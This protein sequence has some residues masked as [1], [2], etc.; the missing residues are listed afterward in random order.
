MMIPA[1][2]QDINEE[3]YENGD[4]IDVKDL[5]G[6]WVAPGT[7]YSKIEIRYDGKELKLIVGKLYTYYFTQL[8]PVFVN[9]IKGVLI[10]WPPDDCEIRLINPY[11]LEVTYTNFQA[12]SS[13]SRYRRYST[14]TTPSAAKGLPKAQRSN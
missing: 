12:K 7:T 8:D 11:L 14:K 6:H 4:T 5:V 3:V 13:I 9:P 2:G 1:S 10:K